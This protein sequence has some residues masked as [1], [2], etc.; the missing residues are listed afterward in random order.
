MAPGLLK[1]SG[2]IL[3]MRRISFVM[4]VG[5]E[6]C[7]VSEGCF[8][9]DWQVKAIVHI[10]KSISKPH[11]KNL[12]QTQVSDRQCVTD[13]ADW[14]CTCGRPPSS[15]QTPCTGDRATTCAFLAR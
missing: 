15:V 7:G 10:P 11:G 5:Y 1:R 2:G 8:Q 6:K 13:A 4:Y 9:L 12:E 3:S 14:A